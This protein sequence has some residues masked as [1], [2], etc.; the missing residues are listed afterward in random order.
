MKTSASLFLTDI[1]PHRRK[2]YHKVVKSKLFSKHTPDEV[3]SQLKK[4]GLDGIEVILPSFQDINDHQLKEVKTLLDAHNLPIFSVHQKLRFFTK[5]KVAEITHLFH[6]ADLVGSKV[7][8]LHMSNAGKQLFNENYKTLLHSLQKKYGITIGFENMEKYFGSYF[9]PHRWHHDKF[10]SLIE[11]TDFNV[12]FDTTHLAHS[13]GDIIEFFKK[14][15]SRIINIHLSDYKHHILNSN[16]RPLRFKHLPLGHGELP[17]QEFIALLVKEQYKGLLT[18]EI[19]G[20]LAGI[21][22]SAEII[23]AVRKKHEKKKAKP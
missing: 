18:M 13:G 22:E 9:A 23:T 20:D 14:N 5:T 19:N 7:I 1:L 3:F 11:E 15:K 4:V 10:A 6:V 16:F 17:M 2:L 8:V 21:C 12:T